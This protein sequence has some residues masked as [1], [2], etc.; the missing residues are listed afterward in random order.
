MQL[1]I[2]PLTP[3]RAAD[4]FAFFDDVAFA[5][6]PQWSWCYCTFF[7]HTDAEMDACPPTCREDVRRV[8]EGY[9]AD[10][11]LSGY[12]AYADGQ[13]VGW[14]NAGD[15]NGY[16]R[17]L[18]DEDI[19]PL[20]EDGRIKAVVCFTIAPDFRRKGVAQQLLARVC[21][22]A[23]AEGYMALE[24]YPVHEEPDAY[25]HYHGHEDMYKKAGFALRKAL[26]G[27][28][29]YRKRLV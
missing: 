15:R 4:Y 5:D 25:A 21:A 29:I 8:A 24:C 11:T 1:V 10:G 7:H 2:H 17:L 9:V 28:S 6:H 18:A 13:V 16:A 22:D 20:P 23:A 12:L 26:P 19:G 27:F 3:V 14:C